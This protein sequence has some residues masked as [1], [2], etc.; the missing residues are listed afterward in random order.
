MHD[1]DEL[2]GRFSAQHVRTRIVLEGDFNINL[3]EYTTASAR[4]VDFLTSHSLY[5]IIF[6]PTRPVSNALLNNIFISWPGLI[7]SRV[8]T[9]DNSDH[10]PVIAI[11]RNSSEDGYGD[12]AGGANAVKYPRLFSN[13]AIEKFCLSLDNVNWVTI[14][15]D[16]N[17]TTAYKSFMCIVQL[18]FHECF[19]LVVARKSC[20]PWFTPGLCESVHTRSEMYKKY[21][22]GKL[23]EEVKYTSYRNTLTQTI[24][25]AK[26][27]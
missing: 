26:E 2:L 14:Y 23:T 4:L 1:I 12:S 5:P 13:K 18:R 22:K 10:L 27:R 8:I 20:T 19:P 16:R 25:L 3:S 7:A 21:L 17:P 11:I 9:A 15:S 6:V 24:K